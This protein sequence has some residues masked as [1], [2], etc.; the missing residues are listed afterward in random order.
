MSE[1]RD[2]TRT[3]VSEVSPEPGGAE[4]EEAPAAEHGAESQGASGA[5]RAQD[6]S[7]GTG[8]DG[9]AGEG[10][11]VVSPSVYRRLTSGFP[12]FL[13]AILSC[14]VVVGF[15]LLVTPRRNP[16]AIPQVDFRSDLNGLVATAPFTVQAPQGLSPKW[17]P[18]SSNLTGR[19]NGPVGWHLGY[20][21]PG[22]QYAALEE[23]DERPD[24]SD[25]FVARMTSQGTPD[26]S[27]QVAGATWDKT[28]RK[29]KNQRS[30]VRRLPGVTLVVT[31]TAS[32]EELA[33]L[34]GSLRPQPKPSPGKTEIHQ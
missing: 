5:E 17:Y 25:G 3:P 30:L 21:T 33:T 26:G 28:F 10:P 9:T 12:G 14:M 7:S 31:G 23:S 27:L 18:T 29:D 15:V 6:P 8:E 2:A 4:P 16:N 13:M 1:A 34:A 19:A 11:I 22:K 32:Y 24:G 20:Y